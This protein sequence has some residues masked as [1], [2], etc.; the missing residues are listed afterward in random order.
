ML[1]EKANYAINKLVYAIRKHNIDLR[2]LFT[3]FDK[4]DD[5]N[6]SIE[7]FGELLKRIDK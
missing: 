5:S 6:L 7:E 1:E 2:K 3:K 4:S